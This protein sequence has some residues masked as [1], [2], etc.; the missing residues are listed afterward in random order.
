[1][2][3]APLPPAGWYSD[4][5]G[6]TGTRY[7]DGTSWTAH[8][9]G[10]EEPAAPAAPAAPAPPTYPA[11]P[12]QPGGFTPYAAYGATDPGINPHAQPSGSATGYWVGGLVSGLIAFIFCPILL[13]PAG[14][15]L[16][17]VAL[18]KGDKLGWIAVVAGV[19]G[20]VVGLAI[21]AVVALDA[22]RS[23]QF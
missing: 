21:G 18:K 10:A 12:G 16:G 20:F 9:R 2:N 13:G 4:P 22:Y 5:E 3:D 23:G 19:L 14:I 1:M 7:W 15:A 8:T 17:V 11:A 6:G